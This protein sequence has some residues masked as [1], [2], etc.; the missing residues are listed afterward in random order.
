[1]CVC[2]CLSLCV[3][4]ISVHSSASKYETLMFSTLLSLHLHASHDV[5]C[6]LLLVVQVFVHDVAVLKV[7][8]VLDA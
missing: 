3:C 7:H 1:M 6:V 2:V 8:V 5:A 4:V